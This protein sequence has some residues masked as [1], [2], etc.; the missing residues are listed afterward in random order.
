MLLLAG[1][2]AGAYTTACAAGLPWSERAANAALQHWAGCRFG[3]VG[4]PPAWTHEQGTLL[5]GMDA[6]WLNTVDLRYFNCIRQSVDPLAGVDGS[7]P[8]LKL[9]ENRL[10]DVQL[11]R[12]LMLLYG[13]TTK[14]KYFK[15]ATALFDQLAHRPR[16]PSGGFSAA[17]NAPNQ[18]TPD[19]A[20]E[21]LPFYANYALTFHHPEVFADITRQFVLLQE[22]TRDPKTGL[23][24]QAWD[25]SKQ[26]RWANKVTGA[27]AQ[28]WGRGMG[29]YMMALVDTLPEYPGDDPGR[30]QLIAILAEDAAAVARYQNAANGLWYEVLDKAGSRGNYPEASASCMFVYALAKGVRLGYLPERYDAVAERGYKG[31]LSYFVTAGPDGS[32][33]LKGTV[34]RTDPGGNP[35]RG[36]SHASYTSKETIIDSPI[37]MGAFI[38][39]SSEIEN[40]QNAKL[41]RGKTVM[42]DAWFNSQKR[43]DS[44]GR[45][46]YFHYKWDDWS[47]AGYSLFGHILHN[48]GAKTATLYAEPTLAGLRRA[49]VF[50]IASPDNAEKNPHPHYANAEDAIQ[51]AEWVKGGGVLVIMENDTS[52]ADLDHFN[53]VAEKF[54]MRFNS[55]L[56]KHVTGTDWAMGK[57]KL[58]GNG[59]IFHHPY[60]IYVKDVCTISLKSPAVPLLKDGGD[61]LMAEAKYGRGTV[62]A[63]VDPWLY[64]EYTDGR[65]LPAEY[66]NYAAGEEFVRW[67]LEQVPHAAVR[68]SAKAAAAARQAR[69]PM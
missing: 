68:A 9:G 19:E 11:G 69:D 16:T 3:P 59:P 32:F 12:Q 55:V 41:G 67:I 33:S 56:R 20:Y 23:L 53:A 36:G 17:R 39:A 4:A 29:W 27:S 46:I 10:V 40:V 26:E 6:V 35:D 58:A 8:A 42:V 25:E 7:L 2:A 1:L 38:L 43:T 61:I 28:A 13:V 34:E 15:A 57:I 37:G 62:F 5:D 24:R 14:R 50:I 54:G 45:E 52:F 64:N 51:L 44:T 63:F 65:K 66:Q 30:G 31:I 18:M 48:F 60:T 21:A 22:H 49:Q 47:P